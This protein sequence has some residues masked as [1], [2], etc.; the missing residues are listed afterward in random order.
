MIL[1]SMRLKRFAVSSLTGIETFPVGEKVVTVSSRRGRMH[2]HCVIIL[3]DMW[4]KNIF[5][6]LEL[7][8][9]NLVLIQHRPV[10]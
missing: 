7:K 1:R 9:Q 2:H 5:R 8:R 6:E 3:R 10:F 4:T